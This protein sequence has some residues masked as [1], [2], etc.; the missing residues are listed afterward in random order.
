VTAVRR[1]IAMNPARWERDR[2]NL[3]GLWI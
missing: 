2:N 1:Y 3:P